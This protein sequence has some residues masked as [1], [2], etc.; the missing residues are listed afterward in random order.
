MEITDPDILHLKQKINTQV[1]PVFIPSGRDQ[2]E[3]VRP[4]AG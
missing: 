1:L 4:L 3:Q 2:V